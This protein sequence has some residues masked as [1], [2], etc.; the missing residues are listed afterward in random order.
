MEFVTLVQI[1]DEAACDSLSANALRKGIEL[2]DLLN[3]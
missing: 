2:S 1:L 3:S